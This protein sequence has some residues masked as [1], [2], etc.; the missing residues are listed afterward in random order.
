MDLSVSLF[1]MK[2]SLV[3]SMYLEG[4][5]FYVTLEAKLCSELLM[6]CLPAIEV[7]TDMKFPAI[8]PKGEVFS[9]IFALTYISSFT[10]FVHFS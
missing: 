3:G 5:R 4:D 10:D 7:L 2:A 8:K 9:D 1:G 6:T